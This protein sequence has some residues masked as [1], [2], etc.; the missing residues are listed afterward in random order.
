MPFDFAV[1]DEY[2]KT[3]KNTLIVENHLHGFFKLLEFQKNEMFSG[4]NPL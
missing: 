2:L 4:K 3:S 1:V